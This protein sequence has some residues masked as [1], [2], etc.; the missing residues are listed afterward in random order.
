[1]DEDRR[2]AQSANRAVGAHKAVDSKV[3]LYCVDNAGLLAK[4][5]DEWFWEDWQ[6]IDK[7]G[8][9]GAASVPS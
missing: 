5:L 3:V 7:T 1:M 6:D 4:W 8:G 9:C 2:D